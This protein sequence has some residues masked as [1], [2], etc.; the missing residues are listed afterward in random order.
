M[1]LSQEQINAVQTGHPRVLVAAASGSG[2][3]TVITER[4]NFL[5]SKDVNPSDIVAITFTNMAA[6]EMLERTNNKDV[7]IGTIHSLANR[8]L[9]MNNIDTSNIIEEQRF[10]ELLNKTRQQGLR[11][12]KIE[13][14]L[15][16]EFQDISDKEAAF[17]DKLNPTN[18]FYCGDSCQ[19]IYS[20]RSGNFAH[21]MNLI[22]DPLVM[23]YKLKQNYR[24]GENIIR[25]AEGYLE[26][27]DDVYLIES[28]AMVDFPGRVNK[29]TIKEPEQIL[30][31]LETSDED[32]FILTRTNSQIDYIAEL[33]SLHEISFETFKKSEKTLEELRD[34]MATTRIKLLTVH[35]AKGLEATNVLA[36]G[37]QTYNPEEKRVCYVACTRAKKRLFVGKL[38]SYMN[39]EMRDAGQSV[40]STLKIDNIKMF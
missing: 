29:T 8:I 9:R 30:D 37:L 5:L 4:I 6:Q 14:L 18:F 13:H 23:K 17:F 12:P 32:W 40:F 22:N 3:T 33:L 36:L 38:N 21:F 31:I 24:S 26:D 2:K 10:D 16:D 20:F 28:D 19:A 15:V 25:Y 11:Y 1:E 7:L 39:K 27:L 34:I 35:S